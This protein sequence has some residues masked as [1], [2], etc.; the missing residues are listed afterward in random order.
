M[1]DDLKGTMRIVVR[2]FSSVCFGIFYVQAL[3]LIAL[4]LADG[5]GDSE[6]ML[7]GFVGMLTCPLAMIGAWFLYRFV[8]CRVIIYIGGAIGL[9]SF[10]YTLAMGLY[11]VLTRPPGF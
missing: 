1:N 5:P 9:L 8:V 10:L 7:A 2:A 4:L 3:M 6:A 11:D